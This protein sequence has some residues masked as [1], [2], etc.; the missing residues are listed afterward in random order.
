MNNLRFKCNK[1]EF[2]FNFL[3]KQALAYSKILV[4]KS[5]IC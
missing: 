2:G 5:I 3:Y 1:K 4:E